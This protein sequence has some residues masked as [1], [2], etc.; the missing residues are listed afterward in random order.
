M[1]DGKENAVEDGSGVIVPAGA[2]HNVINTRQRAAQALHALRP[3]R[4]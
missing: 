4:A 3:A 1:I 2:R